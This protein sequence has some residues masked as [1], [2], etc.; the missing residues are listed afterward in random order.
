VAEI[1]YS[2]FAE[3]PPPEEWDAFVEEVL[4]DDWLRAYGAATPWAPETLAIPQ[5]SLTYL[6]DA[7]PTLNDQ[8]GD[9]RVVAV[10]GKSQPPSGPRD[11]SRQAGFLPEPRAWSGNARD[12]GHLIGHAAG[13]GLDLNLFPQAIG[14]NRGRTPQGKLWRSMEREAAERPGTPLFIRPLYRD[15]SWIPRE[16]EFGLVDEGRMRVERFQNADSP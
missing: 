14:L 12:R 10:W 15:R 4:V 7:A 1:D 9:D 8:D 16:L 6:F 13:G 11:H 5:G 3:L 2:L